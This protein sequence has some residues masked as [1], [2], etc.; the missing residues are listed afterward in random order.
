MGESTLLTL[1]A[2]V[3]STWPLT[4]LPQH[5]QGMRERVTGTQG[6]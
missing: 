4:Y 1:D 6:S 5:T 2:Q 3:H